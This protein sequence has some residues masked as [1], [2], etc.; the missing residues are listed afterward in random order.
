MWWHDAGVCTLALC[1]PKSRCTRRPISPLPVRLFSSPLPPAAPTAT[2]THSH[3]RASGHP[4]PRRVPHC[5]RAVR[6]RVAHGGR[7]RIRAQRSRR[8]RGRCA[9]RRRRGH[10]VR[11]AHARRR[12]VTLPGRRAP[13][14]VDVHVQVPLRVPQGV[15]DGFRGRGVG[16]D[17]GGGRGKRRDLGDGGGCVAAGSGRAHLA[18]AC[19]DPRHVWC[20]RAR[21][22]WLRSVCARC[23]VPARSR[24]LP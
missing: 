7:D 16:Q 3:A 13:Q 18:C 10:R 4:D 11:V 12:A 5:T 14:P 9:A 23:C 8:R 22:L 21:K 2:R 17:G 15:P 19:L 20:G 24:Q 6:P 1:R